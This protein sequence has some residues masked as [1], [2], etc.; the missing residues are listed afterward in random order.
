MTQYT[1]KNHIARS[2]LEATCFQSRE[3][4]DA[5]VTD[6]KMTLSGLKVDGGMTVSDLL[7]QI[8][9]DLL[10]LDVVRTSNKETT[11]VGAAFAAGLAVGFWKNIEDLPSFSESVFSPKMKPEIRSEKMKKWK[12][13][14]SKAMDWI[15]DTQ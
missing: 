14:V 11:A 9:S 5:M 12:K 13:A 1:N 4:F 15:E 7:L 6:A 10:G 2:V 8:Q 3:V